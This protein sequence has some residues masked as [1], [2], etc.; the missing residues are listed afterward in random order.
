MPTVFKTFKCPRCSKS[1]KWSS[2]LKTHLLVHPG[3]KPTIASSQGAAGEK[4]VPKEN[5]NFATQPCIKK[6]QTDRR[7][8]ISSEGTTT[9][10]PLHHGTVSPAQLAHD[11]ASLI[12]D[13]LA[14]M[15]RMES[16]VETAEE[17]QTEP[18]KMS[19]KNKLWRGG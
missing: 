3:D 4:R 7:T 2:T 10:S 19:K 11:A 15:M 5:P 9:A 14:R 17:N 1:F 16:K 6:A 13:L 8:S 12:H 18:E